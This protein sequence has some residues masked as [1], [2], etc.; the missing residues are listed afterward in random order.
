MASAV[1]GEEN[2]VCVAQIAGA[3]GV[4]GEVRLRAFTAEPEGVVTYGPI[5]DQDGRELFRLA[6][7]R[8]AKGGVIARAEGITDRDAAEALRGMMLYVPRRRLPAPDEDEFYHADLIGLD[9]VDLSGRPC[10]RVVAVHNHGAGDLVEI[11]A[12]D[13][14]AVLVPF[15]REAVPEIDLGQRRITVD[16]P[17]LG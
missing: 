7:V 1:K 2:V 14:A 12:D 17:A 15:T 5:C 4:R 6:L 10:G 13:G 9:A 8:V 11:A 16:P 3:H